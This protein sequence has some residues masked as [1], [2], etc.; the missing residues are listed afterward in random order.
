MN[1]NDAGYWYLKAGKGM[2]TASASVS[3][4]GNA[5]AKRTSVSLRTTQ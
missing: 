5:T 2:T 1:S 4:I 3:R